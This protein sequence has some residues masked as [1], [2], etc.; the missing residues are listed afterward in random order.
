MNSV[1]KTIGLMF[2]GIFSFALKLMKGLFIFIMYLIISGA[3]FIMITLAGIVI[4]TVIIGGVN[5]TG[6]ILSVST[7]ATAFF[8]Y[9]MLFKNIFNSD[10]ITDDYFEHLV[11]PTLYYPYD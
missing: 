3:V 10:P 1:L 6:L 5:H 11:D 7:V 2:K 9:L 8:I 4:D